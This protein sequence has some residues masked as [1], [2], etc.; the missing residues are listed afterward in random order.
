MEVIRPTVGGV[1]STPAIGLVSPGEMGAAIGRA[2]AGAGAVVRWASE[3][4]SGASAG[5]AADAG[6]QDAGTL[7][8]LVAGSDV[9]LSVVPP[10]AAVETAQA[11]AALGFA[12][13]YVDANAVSPETAARVG[14]VVRGGGAEWVDGGIVGNPPTALGTTRLY[15]SGERAGEVAAL[16][17]GTDLEAIVLGG[18]PTAASAMKMV[19]AAWAK[20][21]IA[22]VRAV[23]AAADELGVADAL[24]REWARSRPGAARLLESSRTAV[25]R[26]AWRWVGEME[27]IAATLAAAGQ[28]PG[29]HEAAAE[30]FRA[31][32]AG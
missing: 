20:G 25:E 13:L 21:T 16:C 24:D 17:A 19:Y 30:V 1:R 27:E 28:P 5:R 15:L 9:L 31:V 29:F 22:L 26:K 23:H 4:R 6:L 8:E 14:E 11:V 18:S 3:G 7:A 2:L 32:D 12:G 10:H